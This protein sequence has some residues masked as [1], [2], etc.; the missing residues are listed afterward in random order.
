MENGGM[1]K[2]RKKW[3]VAYPAGD[4]EAERGTERIAAAM[5]CS[6]VTAKLLWNRGYR[7][8]EAA[9]GFLRLEQTRFH[10][11]F[12][13]Q[14]M[15]RA[16]ARIETALARGEKI[17]IYGDYD[18]D[19]VT[20]TSLLYLYLRERGADV[21][22]Y[23]PSRLHEGYG[24]S[25]GAIDRLSEQGV[26]LMITVDTGITAIA[27]TAYAKEH[28]ID[29]VITDH[30]ACRDELPQA[31]AAVN[32]HRKDDSYPFSELAGVGVVFKLVCAL[33]MSEAR[34][35]GGTDAEA[36]R[37]I[38]RSY[39]DLV[40]IG[41]VADVMPL[42]DENRLIVSYG[43]NRLKTDCRIGLSA[44]MEAAGGKGKST[45][46]INSTFIGFVIA[47]RM[48]AA[49]RMGDAT[50]AV[51][52]LL[53]DSPARAQALAEQLCALNTERQA[54]E[55]RIAEAAYRK[56]E[57]QQAQQ[58]PRV[59]V[60]DDDDWHQGVIGIVSSRVTERYGLPSILITYDGCPDNDGSGQ[61]IGKGS[62]RSIRGL[63]LVE[64][65]GSCRDLLL[66]FGGHELA[67]GLSVRRAD[68]PELRR[69]LNLY[70]GERLTDEM[71]CVTLDA[72]CEVEMQDLTM[73]LVE[74]TGWLEPFGTGNSAPA[75]VLRNANLRRISPIG[76]GKHLR[77]TVEKDGLTVNAVWFN[78][79]LSGLDFDTE[80]AVDL[81]F[82]L[83]V[84]EFQGNVSLQMVLQDARAAADGEEALAREK[85]RYA[86][87]ES[88][89]S[90]TGEENLLPDRSDC[91]E[92]FRL[93]RQEAALEH[94]GFPVRR[95]LS[96]LNRRTEAGRFNYCKL[97]WILRIFDELKLCT[98]REP[99]PD[100]C[101]VVLTDTGNEKRDLDS[102]VLLCQLRGKM[103]PGR[104]TQEG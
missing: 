83:D 79:G 57:E 73:R 32:P 103:R 9:G 24:L 11:A 14:D 47:P 68:V 23:I 13:M 51:E 92:V 1:E 29:T 8:P 7:T 81:M 12:R 88:G 91:A 20:S 94:T 43:L 77:L 31:V 82:R 70:A 59:L 42:V 54:E 49:G 30:H 102:S 64:A 84:N 89:G 10:D 21:M 48:N 86:E 16:V 61:D 18:V 33:E 85:R 45:R 17:A 56:I 58:T 78:M 27:E 71:L 100:Y 6:S 19:G 3:T 40:A 87:I 72:D 90:F 53:S 60:L 38:C 36:V 26:K 2:R 52:L 80:E 44:L 75:F 5:G 65:L 66:R 98:V 74:E 22:Y 76:G 15:D 104:S 41:T 55:N 4:T 37:R 96:R 97:M 50:V 46:K 99:I 25:A 101:L 93:L 95:L 67:A 28:G 35:T 62:G 63:N 39:A 69:R 34:R